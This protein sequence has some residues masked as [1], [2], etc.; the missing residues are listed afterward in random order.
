MTSRC[1][2]EYYP[3]NAGVRHDK[4]RDDREKQLYYQ[5]CV[6]AMIIRFAFFQSADS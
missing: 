1:L 3:A 2:P 5:A 4:L 6:S